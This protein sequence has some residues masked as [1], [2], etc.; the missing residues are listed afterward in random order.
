MIQNKKNCILK[1]KSCQLNL[2][3]TTTTPV[4]VVSYKEK[5]NAIEKSKKYN[6]LPTE[7]SDSIVIREAEKNYTLKCPSPA[8]Q[9]YWVVEHFKADKIA[10]VPSQERWKQAECII[11][12]TLS[13]QKSND[14]NINNQ[15]QTT[16]ELILDWF[17]ADPKKKMTNKNLS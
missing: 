13:D 2:L 1:T 3:T 9:D 6:N 17:M 14:I 16:I 5:L 7:L 15:L 8:G 10:N 4:K 12:R 11:K